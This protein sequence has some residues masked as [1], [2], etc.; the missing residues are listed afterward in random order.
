MG[1]TNLNDRPSSH[2]LV[3]SCFV[4]V[5]AT[6]AYDFGDLLFIAGLLY[7]LPYGNKLPHLD[8]LNMLTPTPNDVLSGR[9]HSVNNH[10]G[11]EAFRRMLE[12]HMVRA[13]TDSLRSLQIMMNF[14]P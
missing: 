13:T 9:G 6:L 7:S 2:K 11:N 8:Q 14:T 3:E 5:E 1:L 12:S 10:P 4:A